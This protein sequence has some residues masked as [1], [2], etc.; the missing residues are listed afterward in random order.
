VR[1]R[2]YWAVPALLVLVLPTSLFSA[3]P[4]LLLADA[5]SPIIQNER[6]DHEDLSRMRDSAMVRSFVQNGRLV[7]IPSNDR[8]YYVYAV[9]AKY[10]Y[11]RPWTKLFLARLSRQYHARFGQRLRVT[12]LVRTE[13]HQRRLAQSN[14]NAASSQGL[15]RSSHLTG[16]TVDISKRFMSQAEVRWVRSVLYSLHSEGY[17]YA[18]EEFGQPVFHIMVYRSYPEYVLS[19]RRSSKRLP[20]DVS[21]TQ[22]RCRTTAHGDRRQCLAGVSPKAD[23]AGAM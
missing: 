4:V 7:N 15:L 13:G 11:A 9:P 21:K 2:L 10:R 18:F 1:G 5:S 6:A 3:G 17:I 12:S 22:A 8:N 20:K 23:S 14:P 16:A 19:L